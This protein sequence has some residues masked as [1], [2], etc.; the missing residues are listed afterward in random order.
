MERECSASRNKKEITKIAFQIFVIFGLFPRKLL[1]CHRL[2]YKRGWKLFQPLT[3][4][5]TINKRNTVE[6]SSPPKIQ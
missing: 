2:V 1:L 6:I 4:F 5:V 3:F